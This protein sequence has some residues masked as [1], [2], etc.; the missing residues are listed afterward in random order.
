MQRPWS[1]IKVVEEAINIVEVIQQRDVPTLANFTQEAMQLHNLLALLCHSTRPTQ[2]RDPLVN[3]FRSHVMTS[4]E[5]LGILQIKTIDKITTKE[6]NK[7]KWR[8]REKNKARKA[9]DVVVA[10]L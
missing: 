5:Y 1:P 3:Y 9:I 10:T 7:A 6:H 4:I 2:G 8:E